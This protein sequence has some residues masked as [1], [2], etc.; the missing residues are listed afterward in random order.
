MV[1]MIQLIRGELIDKHAPARKL[2]RT[3]KDR[4]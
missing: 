1:F 2:T 3:D 4:A